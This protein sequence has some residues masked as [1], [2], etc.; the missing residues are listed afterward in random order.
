[1]VDVF[2][3]GEVMAMME[4]MRAAGG[5]KSCKKSA[6][7]HFSSS[8]YLSR[9]AQDYHRESPLR[10]DSSYKYY[11][12]DKQYSSRERFSK[13]SDVCYVRGRQNYYKKV[14]PEIECHK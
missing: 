7:D 2:I 6:K 1:M 12:K 14:C 11:S 8:K 13:P 10:R 5:K 4:S 9:S 3:P